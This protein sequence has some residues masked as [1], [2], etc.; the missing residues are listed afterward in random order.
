MDKIIISP[1]KYVQGEQVLSAIASY[2]KTLGEHP[3]VIADEF[4][5]NLVGD[6]VKESFA[7]EKLPLSMNIFHGECCRVEIERITDLCA[8]QKHDVIVG[9]GGGK[10]SRHRQISRVLHQNSCGCGTDHRIHR[11]PNLG[12]GRDL[13]ARR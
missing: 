9:V 12:L 6:T 3:L 1:S 2:V 5:M 7:S 8:T 13:H 10:N 11:R 4:V